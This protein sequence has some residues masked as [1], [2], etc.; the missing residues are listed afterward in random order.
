MEPAKIYQVPVPTFSFFWRYII[1]YC[2]IVQENGNFVRLKQSTQKVVRRR[3]YL[4]F[5]TLSYKEHGTPNF[6]WAIA[7]KK[8]I[9]NTHSESHLLFMIVL[10]KAE[11][12][13]SPKL[14]SLACIFLW[15]CSLVLYRRHV[16]LLYLCDPG[17]KYHVADILHII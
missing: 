1:T 7:I 6:L 16:F 13:F 11:V 15:R 4:L 17:K 8:L 14:A 2:L 12:T 9:F 3:P 5:V 10:T